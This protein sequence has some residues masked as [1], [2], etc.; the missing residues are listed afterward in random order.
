MQKVAMILSSMVDLRVRGGIVPAHAGRLDKVASWVNK[1]RINIRTAPSTDA[2]RITLVDRW[3]K[4][5][6]LGRQGDWSRI[7]LQS[8]VIGWVLTKYLSPT[9]PPQTRQVATRSSRI[10]LPAADK[11]S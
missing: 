6:V 9:K 1:D 10:P 11:G 3:T 8:G 2:Q 4:V 7:R 5:Q